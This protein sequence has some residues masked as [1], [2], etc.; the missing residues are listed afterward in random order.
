MKKLSL[1]LSSLLF[2][3]LASSAQT[4]NI[5]AKDSL[6]DVITGGPDVKSLAYS[7]D[8]TRDSL[9]FKLE[10]YNQISINSSF[11]F[12]IGLDTDNVTT[13]G[14]A[15]LGT[16]TS[17]KYDRAFII[18]MNSIMPG[19]YYAEAGVPGF[20]TSI[21]VHV[22]RPDNNTF[23]INTK[24]SL[25]D[26]DGKFNLLASTSDFDAAFV[27]NPYIY[28]EIPDNGHGYLSVPSFPSAIQKTNENFK[29]IIVYPNPCVGH[30]HVEG[31]TLTQ[32]S[33]NIELLS[34]DGKIVH[35]DKVTPQN[36]ALVYTLSTTGL[37]E[38]LY[39]LKLCQGESE[40]YTQIIVSK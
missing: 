30:I 20:T 37:N 11:G 3:T 34:I 39:F 32:G 4:F 19:F 2:I 29:D 21:P 10:T 1:F 26:P 16:N 15:W 14:H 5:I 33:V 38:G 35:S 18:M 17:M 28:D 7:I 23:I 40:Q 8:S 25:L 6:G 31:H 13:N 24:L 9:W 12:I 22:Q 27:V 36:T